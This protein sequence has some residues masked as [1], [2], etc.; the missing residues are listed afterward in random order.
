M[1]VNNIVR[2]TS[3]SNTFSTN[4]VTSLNN[5]VHNNAFNN[6]LDANGP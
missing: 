4:G 1:F 3:V 2:N 6:Y 5:T